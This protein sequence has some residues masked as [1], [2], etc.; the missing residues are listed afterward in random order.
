[1][2]NGDQVN[3]GRRLE[4]KSYINFKQYW[5]DQKTQFGTKCNKIE[6]ES[7][8]KQTWDV[9]Q[10]EIDELKRAVVFYRCSAEDGEITSNPDPVNFTIQ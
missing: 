5:A 8:H 9:R 4:K 2:E 1:M 7:C 6:A 3:N 10:Q